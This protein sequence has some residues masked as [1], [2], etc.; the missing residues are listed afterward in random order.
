[1][2]RIL[3]RLIGAV[4]VLAFASVVNAGM[5]EV[6]LIPDNPGPYYGGESLTVDVW[7]HSQID[8]DVGLRRV[9]LDFTNSDPGL[10]LGSTFEFDYA[11]VP[12][13]IGGYEGSTFPDLPVPST[14]NLLGCLCPSAFIR[15]PALGSVRLGSTTLELASDPGM[16]ALDVLNHDDPNLTHGATL[17]LANLGTPEVVWRAYTGDLTD[18]R[19]QFVVVPEPGTLTLALVVGLLPTARRSRQVLCSV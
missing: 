12:E 2:S 1:M 6:E 8:N 7:V 9:Q 4:A 3:R 10:L 18:G 15:L 14:T 13:D 19:Y 16:Y 17:Q 5:V 11:G